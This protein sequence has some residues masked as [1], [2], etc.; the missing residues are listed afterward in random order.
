[1]RTARVW[2]VRPHGPGPRPA[3]TPP[4]P[5]GDALPEETRPSKQAYPS[6]GWGPG[7]RL[8]ASAPRHEG[9]A[10]LDPSLR[11]GTR[12]RFAPPDD[13]A[14]FTLVEVLVSLAIFAILAV[15]GLGLVE[16]VL[17]VEERTRGRLEGVAAV[18]RAFLVFSRDIEGM[19]ASALAYADG[20]LTARALPSLARPAP[21]PV[22]YGAGDGAFVRTLAGREQT[23]V[24]GVERI[25]W[26]FF[27]SGVGWQPALPVRAPA[28][29]GV[30]TP[31]PLIPRA[32]EVTLTLADGAGTIRRVARL[33]A[34]PPA[35]PPT[36]T[37]TLGPRT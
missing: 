1:M 6:E 15:A 30:S 28:Q 3:S 36:D 25:D 37:T 8:V 11:W 27:L 23:L 35:P 24:R 9:V 17:S 29:P 5:C 14:G 10:T 7:H 31:P 18:Q 22:R 20:V 21:P 16:G 2:G 4:A 13:Q 34:P 32:V 33:P 26:R 12:R 19:D